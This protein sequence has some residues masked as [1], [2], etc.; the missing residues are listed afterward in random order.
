[1]FRVPGF[2]GLNF[3]VP[4]HLGTTFLVKMAQPRLLWVEVIP[5]ELRPRKICSIS[6]VIFMN[7][8]G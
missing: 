1:M 4:G 5:P 6:A 3:R 7:N 8:N 2:L